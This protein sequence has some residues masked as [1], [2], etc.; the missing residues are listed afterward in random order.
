MH[1][2]NSDFMEHGKSLARHRKKLVGCWVRVQGD[3]TLST[4]CVYWGL[5]RF[6]KSRQSVSN[7]NRSGRPS[8]SASDENIKRV[9]KLITKDRLLTVD[10]IADELQISHESM[11]QIITKIYTHGQKN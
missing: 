8:T 10:T 3:Q 7:K 9:R 6:L 5:T 1:W 4:K 11:Q 2:T